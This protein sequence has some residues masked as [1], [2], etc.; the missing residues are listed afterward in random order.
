MTRF[1][2][3]ALGAC[4][5]AYI[6]G[7]RLDEAFL[8]SACG[9]V[10]LVLLGW[11]G[12]VRDERPEEPRK[13]SQTTDFLALTLPLGAWILVDDVL[14]PG[15]AAALTTAAV[16]AYAAFRLQTLVVPRER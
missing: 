11:L 15:E 10:A 1:L 3:V 14:P 4:A 6:V 7:V 2:A 13:V 9:C 5:C 8:G 16:A 12:N